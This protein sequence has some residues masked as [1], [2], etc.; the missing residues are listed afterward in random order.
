MMTRDVILD[1]SVQSSWSLISEEDK[2]QIRAILRSHNLLAP[3]GDIVLAPDPEEEVASA[4][5]VNPARTVCMA[6][7][8]AAAAK[9]ELA[10]EEIDDPAACIACAIAVKAAQQACYNACP[11]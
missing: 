8:D 7:C 1:R 9:A 3:D 5:K 11:I 4:V 6:A 10:C 2:E